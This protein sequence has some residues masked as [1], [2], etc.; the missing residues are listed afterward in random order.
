MAVGKASVDICSLLGLGRV[1]R[2]WLD[3]VD[4]QREREQAWQREGGPRVVG[5]VGG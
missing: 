2:I 5:S 1:A 3:G 4:Y